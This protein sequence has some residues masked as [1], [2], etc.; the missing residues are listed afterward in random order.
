MPHEP[1]MSHTDSQHVLRAYE[2]LAEVTSRMREAAALEDWETVMSLEAECAGLYSSVLTADDSCATDSAYQQRKAE[3]ICK[4][5]DDDAQIRG[6]ISGELTRI[7]RLI[8][9]RERVEQLSSAYGAYSSGAGE[10]ER[11]A[12]D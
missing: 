4:L 12:R 7:W 3:L 1:D 10:V 2:R 5:L 8:H 6:Q 9:G 11:S